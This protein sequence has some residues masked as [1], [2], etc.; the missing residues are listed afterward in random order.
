LIILFTYV[1]LHSLTQGGNAGPF[2][3]YMHGQSSTTY[4][5]LIQSR[6]ANSTMQIFVTDMDCQSSTMAAPL[7]QGGYTSLILGVQQDATLSSSAR[8]LHFHE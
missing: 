4:A 3:N 8:K 5:P 6:Y 2:T 7:I 1:Q